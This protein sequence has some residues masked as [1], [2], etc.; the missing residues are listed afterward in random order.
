MIRSTITDV[1]AS[2]KIV[3]AYHLFHTITRSRMRCQEKSANR[4]RQP[5]GD[6]TQR[7]TPPVKA[8]YPA[9]YAAGSPNPKAPAKANRR[10]QPPGGI[11]PRPTP[12][13]QTD[14]PAAY[15]AGSPNPR[16][17]AKANRRRQPPGG[18][19]PRPTPPAQ[20]DYPAAYAAGSPNPRAP[21]KGEPAASAAG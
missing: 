16:A 12:P 14:Y 9:A 18:I 1:S 21:A 6:F 7:P 19:T 4:R 13:T 11:T 15:A 10:R 20:T 3:S 2:M 5:P 17:S 8:D